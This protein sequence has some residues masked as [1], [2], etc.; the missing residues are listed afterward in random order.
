MNDTKDG[1]ME[2]KIDRKT[3]R[4][5]ILFSFALFV[6]ATAALSI[7][8]VLGSISAEW[9][10]SSTASALLVTAFGATFALS[11]PILQMLVGHWVRRTQILT[12]ISTMAVGAVAFALAPNYPV[13]F[14]ARILMGLGAAL[15]SPV[16]FAL[17]TSMVKPQQQGGALAVVS[18]GISIATVIGVPSSAWL[19]AHVG[20]RMLF[21]IIALLLVATGT[22]IALF[23]PDRSKGERVSTRQAL[24]LLKRPSTL[25]GLFV[26]FFIAA[27]I[28]TTYTMITPIMRDLYGADNHTISMALL[29]FG[30]SGLAGNFFVRR[31]SSRWSAESLLKGSMLILMSIFA[32]LLVLPISLAV[33]L[34]ALVA[35]PFVSDIIWPS[36]QRRMVE[37]ESGFRGIALAL[38]SS[39]MFSGMAFGSALGGLTYTAHGFAAV[40]LLSILLVSLGLGALV[41]S[42]RTRGVQPSSVAIAVKAL[43]PE[44]LACVARAG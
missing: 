23:I 16:M 26:V 12:G 40:L 44:G 7:I 33:L 21:A 5:L 22:L 2:S 8:G 28:F 4:S 37:L 11:A 3:S 36:Q 35:W 13:L 34:T 19:A 38:S 31:A 29:V 18:M 17:G 30:V 27:G 9:R 24:K 14:S 10:I 20:P 42:M 41:Y 25:G 15:L 32:A 6:Q 1:N 39:F 43:K